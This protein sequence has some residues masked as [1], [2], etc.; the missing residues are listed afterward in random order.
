M[1][2]HSLHTRSLLSSNFIDESFVYL[3][4][5]SGQF[6]TQLFLC[7]N[8]VLVQLVQRFAE[9][10]QVLQKRVELHFLH[11]NKDKLA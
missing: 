5:P 2:L 10:S 6:S 4:N 11:Y 7:K 1:G 8:L 3:K 9:F